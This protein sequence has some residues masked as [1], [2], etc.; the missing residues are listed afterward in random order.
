MFKNIKKKFAFTTAEV[1]MVL[2]IIG[3]VALLVMPGMLEDVQNKQLAGRAKK[4][5]M[6]FNQVLDKFT[7]DYESVGDLEGTGFFTTTGTVYNLGEE[8]VK[9]FNVANNC[10]MS[11]AVAPLICFST[12]QNQGK[13]GDGNAGTF[14]STNYYKFTTIDGISYSIS[15]RAGTNTTDT[16]CASAGTGHMA[17]W[18]GYVRLDVNG[19]EPPNRMGRDAFVFYISNGKGAI[20][21]PVG[22]SDVAA[23]W[24]NGATKYCQKGVTETNSNKCTGRLYEEDW[25]MNY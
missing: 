19:L 1:L 11:A 18:C 10:G 20:L 22:G 3:V 16:S 23:S 24:W 21:Y 15:N 4:A 8:L 12:T 17:S 6:E 14:N 25:V 7:T 5:Y 9:Y 2:G 13:D